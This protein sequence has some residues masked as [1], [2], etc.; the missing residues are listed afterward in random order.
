M[1]QCSVSDFAADALVQAWS[2]L[3]A[4]ADRQFYSRDL[5]FHQTR[6]GEY[7][8]I[9]SKDPQRGQPQAHP[10]NDRAAVHVFGPEDTT[11]PK[12]WATHPSN[13]D[14][15]VNAKRS[16]IR[17]AID[18]RPSWFLFSEVT[19]LR[20]K[21]T[22]EVY[23][24]AGHLENPSLQ[25]PEVVQTFIDEEHTETTYDPRYHGLYDDRYIRLDNLD[26]LTRSTPD[27]IPT[28]WMMVS[29]GG[30]AAIGWG[31]SIAETR[32][33]AGCS[34]EMFAD[35]G[36]GG[37]DSSKYVRCHISKNSRAQRREL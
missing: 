31:S 17:S 15:E 6:A 18:E 27:W 34:A 20:E 22:R 12:M 2:D 28:Y 14:R 3:A 9:R 30:T 21:V 26:S 23:Q 16:Y 25:D 7:L 29:L 19:T 36:S 35:G 8:R 4:A 13:Y 11:V 10:E 32:S 24:A 5:F 33:Q 1:G 37:P